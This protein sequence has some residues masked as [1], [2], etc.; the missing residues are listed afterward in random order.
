[1]L[2]C[3]AIMLTGNI[4]YMYLESVEKLNIGLTAKYW[5]LISRAIMGIGAG[6]TL[7]S[8]N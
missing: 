2:V 1:M 6:K 4:I 7:Q 5:M 8:K 3:L